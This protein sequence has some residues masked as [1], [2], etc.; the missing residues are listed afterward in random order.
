MPNSFHDI[1]AEEKRLYEEYI[2]KKSNELRK[3]QHE[4]EAVGQVFKGFTLV[5]AATAMGYFLEV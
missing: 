1:K 4:N 5:L 2:K 3:V